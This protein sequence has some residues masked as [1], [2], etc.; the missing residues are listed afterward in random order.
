MPPRKKL[1]PMVPTP[2]P[3]QV[4]APVAVKTESNIA[5]GTLMICCIALLG[6]FGASIFAGVA[7][8]TNPYYTCSETAEKA[9]NFDLASVMLINATNFSK[10]Y[11]DFSKVKYFDVYTKSKAQCVKG[12]SNVGYTDSCLVDTCAGT[13]C[14][15]KTIASCKPT[16]NNCRLQEA[17][18]MTSTDLGTATRYWQQTSATT[19][20][21]FS[22]WQYK[23][24]LGCSNGACVKPP[25]C[26]D[27]DIDSNTG[28]SD[29]FMMGM[30][31]GI[32]SL[33]QY[34]SAI[35][36]CVGTSTL[37]ENFCLNGV[38]TSTSIRCAYGCIS[39]AC[40]TWNIYPIITTASLPSANL[41]NGSLIIAKFNITAVNGGISWRRMNLKYSFVHSSNKPLSGCA[42]SGS[43]GNIASA[44]NIGPADISIDLPAEQVIAKSN[45]NTYT[46]KCNID[47]IIGAGDT[48]STK[49]DG[50][51]ASEPSHTYIGLINQG[52]NRF[53][54]SDRSSVSHSMNS[55]DWFGSSQVDY[56]P[57]NAWVLSK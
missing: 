48:L 2:P 56:L 9:N 33:G 19:R 16:D 42:I 50:S 27:S 47:G 7:G 5:L 57:S 17:F 30:T 31:T 44:I 46:I 6:A 51:F 26:T 39:G 20:S 10:Y 38:T 18:I 43:L 45:T 15:A 29:P 52:E 13:T 41:M 14:T 32:N 49:I 25:V 3:L 4:S 28:E 24:P 1:Q 36:S 34:G 12:T 55:N 23:C 11:G 35:D 37:I 22:Q 40:S 21:T 8:I 54:W 53:I